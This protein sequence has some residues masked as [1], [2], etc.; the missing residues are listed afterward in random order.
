M[1]L[2]DRWLCT[3]N[4]ALTA[5]LHV[6]ITTAVRLGSVNLKTVETAHEIAVAA[7]DRLHGKLPE[8]NDRPKGLES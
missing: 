2:L 1:R 3:Y 7:A 6:G 8:S 5:T 4:A